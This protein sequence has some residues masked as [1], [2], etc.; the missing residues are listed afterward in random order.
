MTWIWRALEGSRRNDLDTYE[1]TLLLVHN[2][3]RADPADSSS[4]FIGPVRYGHQDLF[5]GALFPKFF[6]YNII[7]LVVMM[8]YCSINDVEF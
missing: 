3:F 1:T 8:N 7:S 5:H 6:L 4:E 2:D